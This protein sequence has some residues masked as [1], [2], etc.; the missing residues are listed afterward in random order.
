MWNF[1]DFSV[2]HILHEINFG[3][4]RRSKTAVCAVLGALKIID[5]VDL[6]PSEIAKIHK[7][8]NLEPL[9]MFKWQILHFYLK[10][11]K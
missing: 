9:D 7:N 5:L 11:R 8:H 3:E 1:Q 2:R 10:I 6:Y 4:S